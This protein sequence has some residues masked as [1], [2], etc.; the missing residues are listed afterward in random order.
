[1]SPLTD[2][3]EPAADGLRDNRRVACQQAM[4]TMLRSWAGILALAADE[5]GLRSVVDALYLPVDEVKVHISLCERIYWK[6]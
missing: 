1:M 2:Q 3:Y 4:V 5:N 6:F